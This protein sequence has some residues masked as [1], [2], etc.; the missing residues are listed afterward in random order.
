VL[1]QTRLGT[2]VQGF[3]MTYEVDG[4]QYVAITAARDGGS[5]WRV[6]TF[7]ATEFSEPRRGE[8]PLRVPV[9][10]R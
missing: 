1:W 4:V 10:A 2:S 7:M 5:P 8:R 3:P 9:G 6:A